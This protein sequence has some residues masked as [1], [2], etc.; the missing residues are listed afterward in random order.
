MG[1]K[2]DLTGQRFG[3]L[4]VIERVP[5]TSKYKCVKL[6]CLCDC[7]NERI[8]DRDSLVRGLT[9]SCGCL[10][11]ESM[12]INHHV[13][14]CGDENTHYRHGKTYTRLYRIWRGMKQ[15][16]LNP[17]YHSFPEYG[18]RGI[19]ICDEWIDDFPQFYEW[20]IANGYRDDLTIDRM[21]NDKGYCPTNCRWATRSEQNS[22]QRRY[23]NN[24]QSAG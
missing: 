2:T 12:R 14:Q 19:T 5:N 17:N 3:R 20:S 13:Q 16:C 23:Q 6:R 18:G 21:D 9:R 24:K 4:T 10:R 11:R 7:G 15:R 8:V 1:Q 22:N